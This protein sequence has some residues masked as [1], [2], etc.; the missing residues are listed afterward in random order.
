ML[1]ETQSEQLRV[2]TEALKERSIYLPEGVKLHIHFSAHDQEEDLGDP[3]YFQNLMKNA[4][5]YIPEAPGWINEHLVVAEKISKGDYKAYD[6]YKKSGP[7]DTFGIATMRGIYNSNKKI[8]LVDIKSDDENFNSVHQIHTK[9]LAKTA[10]SDFLWGEG[11]LDKIVSQFTSRSNVLTMGEGYREGKILTNLGPAIES[12]IDSSQKLK[13]KDEVNVLMTIG[14]MHSPIYSVLKRHIDDPERVTRSFG[15]PVFFD[16]TVQLYRYERFG[17]TLTIEK[18]RELVSKFLMT[19]YLKVFAS[20]ED[21]WV[22]Y[23]ANK[24]T[25]ASLAIIKS[26]SADEINEVISS[27]G[28]PSNDLYDKL[29][30]NIQSVADNPPVYPLHKRVK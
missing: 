9:S 21:R 11:D 13:S 29:R 26:L 4:D 22:D 18:S 28:N 10:F 12:A 25:I 23:D 14:L 15:E 24:M 19:L 17:K 20:M 2:S 3:A 16:P 30:E 8:L 27:A 5:I 1:T 6:N 7:D